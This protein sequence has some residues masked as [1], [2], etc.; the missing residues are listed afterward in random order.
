MQSLTAILI[1]AL[2]TVAAYAGGHGGGHDT[3]EEAQMDPRVGWKIDPVFTV[4]ETIKGYTPP[5][6]LDGIGAWP[7]GRDTVKVLVTHELNSEGGYAYRLANGTELTGARVSF[8]D[9]HKLKRTVRAAGLAYDTVYDRA[10]KIVEH[11][12]QINEG[13]AKVAPDTEGFERFCSA[14]GF[15]KGTDGLMDDVFFTG[16]ETSEFGN[17]PAAG[18]GGQETV[19]DVRRRDLYVV[20]MLGRAAFENICT[21]ENFDSDKVAIIIGDDRQAAPLYLYIGEKGAAPKKGYNPGRFLRR[22]GLGLGNLYVW[23]A[24][25]GDTT[26][27][28]FNGTG[29]MRDGRFVKIKHFDPAKA[30]TLGWDSL[31][32]AS[33]AVQ[34]RKAGAVGA[35]RFSRPEDVSG[36]PEDGTQIV[37]A[38]TGRGGLFPSDNWGT[39]YVID[40]DGVA[41]EE[42]LGK[43]LADIDT[44][45]ARLTIL[46]DDDDPQFRDF[47]V[48]SA[49]NLDWADNGKIYVN[50]DRATVIS[51]PKDPAGCAADAHPS[52]CRDW[53][54]G[55]RSKI[56]ASIWEV[57]P[58]VL[59]ARSAIDPVMNTT[60]IVN[61]A[62]LVR[63]AVMN[64]DAALPDA[65][66][67]SDPL[68][69]GD[70]ESSGVL[71]VTALF[72]TKPGETLLVSDVEAH[73]VRDGS[74]V[75]P[76]GLV[77]GGQLLFLSKMEQ[78][79]KTTSETSRVRDTRREETTLRRS[80]AHT[81]ITPSVERAHQ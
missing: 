40:I 20:P 2:Y 60:Q 51:V 50:E 37:M 4:G 47:G 43:D 38:S 24:N 26:P 42:A 48:R 1:L 78:E 16:E 58:R 21:V 53:A 29:E 74:I 64:R 61:S 33:M 67:D 35:F 14:Y 79:E 30:N 36:N 72:V 31:G 15:E 11:A 49:D 69:I 8:F 6:I 25:N 81:P 71:D 41:L 39:L 70:W 44:I 66:T 52:D 10:G 73:S 23:V 75:D 54:F 7:N 3:S 76:L 17:T 56:E 5:G 77:Q 46:L 13:K 57:D 12:F 55:G 34:N 80:A 59:L 22:N 65:Q 68:D 62:A 9:I 32:F 28:Q 63:I 19:I 27:D 45:P 18:F